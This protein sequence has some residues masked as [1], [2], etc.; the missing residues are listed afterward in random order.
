[1]IV[2]ELEQRSPEWLDWRKPLRMASEAA[3]ACGKSDYTSKNALAKQKRGESKPFVNSA[4]QRGTNYE[5]EAVS[6]YEAK[7]S[8][9]G[10]SVC[11]QDGEYGAS[12]DWFAN[13]SND[14][15]LMAEM[16]VPQ[17]QESNL[18]KEALAGSIPLMYQIQ[19]TQQMA[20]VGA[21]YC[22][23]VVYMPEL[24]DGIIIPFYFDPILWEDIKKCWDS[25]W[26]E[27]M[28]SDLPETDRHDEEW[29]AAVLRFMD[30]KRQED[31][32]K[33]ELNRA[34][35]AL[36]NLAPCGASGMG[37]TVTLVKGKEGSIDYKKAISKMGLD[38][39]AF[40]KYRKAASDTYYTVTIE[41][42]KK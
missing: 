34:R 29:Q 11:V 30:V 25:F 40:E 9:I 22:D 17:S 23:F 15:K 28:V 39:N 27:Y 31:A 6:W 41:K 26:V 12:L 5:A 20:I 10:K 14:Q 16:K 2:V 4:M 33:E 32:I 8:V 19:M 36:T 1:M 3:A 7:L 24:Q 37:V 21:E 38:P 18:W 13:P 35:D 42:D